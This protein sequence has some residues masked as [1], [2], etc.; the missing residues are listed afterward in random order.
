MKNEKTV[1]EMPREEAAG[2]VKQ[3]TGV[4]ATLFAQRVDMAFQLK[5]GTVLVISERDKADLA[6]ALFETM[7]LQMN[8][9]AAADKNLNREKADFLQSMLEKDSSI[10]EEL[11]SEYHKAILKLMSE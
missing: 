7:Q 1:F 2:I 8:L 10:S 11:K 4:H 6:K 5:D 9:M 3:L